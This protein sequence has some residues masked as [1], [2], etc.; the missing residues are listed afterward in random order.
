MNICHKSKVFPAK[1]SLTTKSL[2]VSSI[3]CT[4]LLTHESAEAALMF[5]F[6]YLT[7]GIGFSDATNGAARQSAL[8]Q[9]ANLLG[10]YFTNYNATLTFDVNSEDNPGSTTLASAGSG[11]VNSPSTGFAQTVVQNKIINGVDDNGAAA[12]GVINWNFG[13][14]GGWDLDDNVSGSAYDFKSTAMHELLHAFGF[15]GQM[16]SNGAGVL[17]GVTVGTDPD[18]YAIFDSFLTDGSGNNLVN[19]S[20]VFQSS[21]LPDLTGGT[22]SNGVFFSGTHANAANGGNPVNIYSPN[23]FEEGSSLGHLDDAFFTA[24]NLLMEAATDVGPGARTLSTIEIG[25]LRDIGYTNINPSPVPVPATVWLMGSGLLALIG[26]G[27]RRK[28]AV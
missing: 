5:Q 15:T 25:I 23:P 2:F 4:S 10:A 1:K 18:L 26:V 16:G 19:G 9:S 17:S 20:G 13:I 12:D 27:R 11:L 28:T 21:E 7:P 24:Q 6:N 3:L 14:P 8:E 22:G